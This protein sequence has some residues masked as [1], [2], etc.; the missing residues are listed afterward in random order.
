[1]CRPGAE[2]S[3]AQ[4]PWGCPLQRFFQSSSW[5]PFGLPAPHSLGNPGRAS[6]SPPRATRAAWMLR[7]PRS[8]GP[9]LSSSA[10][11][12]GTTGQRA[13]LH[14]GQRTHA[15]KRSASEGA[16]RVNGRGFR[17]ALRQASIPGDRGLEVRGPKTRSRDGTP[18]S[19]ARS[20][21]REAGNAR[22]EPCTG[23]LPAARKGFRV[24][25]RPAGMSACRPQ[26]PL[27]RARPPGPSSK[28]RPGADLRAASV[29]ETAPGE[30]GPMPWA[31]RSQR[32]SPL[33]A[34]PAGL[35]PAVEVDT[36]RRHTPARGRT[37][38]TLWIRPGFRPSGPSRDATCKQVGARRRSRIPSNVPEGTNSLRPASRFC[39]HPEGQG[40]EAP[41]RSATA[42]SRREPARRTLDSGVR[43]Q[44]WLVTPPWGC[45]PRGRAAPL[46]GFCL[47]R[48]W[49]PLPCRGF[50]RD[51]PHVLGRTAQAVPGTS[52][53]PSGGIA[54]R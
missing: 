29:K 37:M 43:A 45:S 33:R 9:V 21:A 31:L 51:S 32:R 39:P 8:G 16:L 10:R 47:F 17:P 20:S 49:R 27:V 30:P 23:W 7:R 26:P 54:A 11:A 1:M 4:R 12:P 6:A 25:R 5:T 34:E 15:P 41:A 50:R 42:T 35:L 2:F 36:R 48:D 13:T 24:G 53:S 28:R 3:S 38:T 22:A 19:G 44:V 18:R 40:Q 14:N 46:L 52:G